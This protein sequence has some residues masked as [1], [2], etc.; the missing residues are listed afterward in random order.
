MVAIVFT[1]N[2]SFLLD[3]TVATTAFVQQVLLWLNSK[4]QSIFSQ[5][6]SYNQ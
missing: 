2:F 6:S 3:T 5:P 4:V 1:F